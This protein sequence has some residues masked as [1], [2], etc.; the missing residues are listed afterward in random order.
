MAHSLVLYILILFIAQVSSETV[1]IQAWMHEQLFYL[2]ILQQDHWCSPE[3][4]AFCDYL[5][6]LSVNEEKHWLVRVVDNNSSLVLSA[7]NMQKLFF[8]VT[9]M[10]FKLD[11]HCVNEGNKA[12]KKLKLTFNQLISSHLE[13][14]NHFCFFPSLVYE[15]QKLGATEMTAHLTLGTI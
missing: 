11:L 3:E 5:Q 13:L 12:F 9:V 4:K 10:K 7:Q 8:I 15:K 14:Y 6:V 1:E 2:S